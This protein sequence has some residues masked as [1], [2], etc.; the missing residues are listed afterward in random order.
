[1]LS[2]LENRSLQAVKLFGCDLASAKQEWIA[3][4]HGFSQL[5]QQ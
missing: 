1:M 4:G 3:K 5:L 2:L